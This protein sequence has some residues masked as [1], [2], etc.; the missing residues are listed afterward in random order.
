MKSEIRST[1][2]GTISNLVCVV[3]PREVGVTIE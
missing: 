1:K 2:Y 3:E